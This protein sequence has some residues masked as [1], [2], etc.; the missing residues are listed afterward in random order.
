MVL[1]FVAQS[2]RDAANCCYDATGCDVALLLLSVA[3]VVWWL[4]VM[5]FSERLLR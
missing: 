1:L 3:T 4:E 5:T 2:K